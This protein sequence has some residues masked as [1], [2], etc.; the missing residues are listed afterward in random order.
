MST[1]TR[2]GPCRVL[3][4][5]GVASLLWLEDAIASYNV[6]TVVF[7]LSLLVSDPEAAARSLRRD[8]WIDVKTDI[9]T[10]LERCPFVHSNT[11]QY[12]CLDPPA[13]EERPKPVTGQLPPIPRGPPPSTRTVLL[14]ARDYNTSIEPLSSGPLHDGNFLPPLHILVDGLISGVL[15][16]PPENRIE[17]R[18]GL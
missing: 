10:D 8:G 18:L 5:D 12:I 13:I 16:A 2:Y 4:R 6:P 11:I 14:S 1:R 17:G 9:E 3:R 15:D 7:D